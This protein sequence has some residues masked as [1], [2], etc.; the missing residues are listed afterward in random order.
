MVSKNLKNLLTRLII[1]GVSTLKIRAAVAQAAIDV[2]QANMDAVVGQRQ[3][4]L[5]NFQTL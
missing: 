2:L 5:E 1:H 3:Q 4:A